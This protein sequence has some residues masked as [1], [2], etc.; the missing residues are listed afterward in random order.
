MPPTVLADVFIVP[1]K[2]IIVHTTPGRSVSFFG[3]HARVM[4]HRDMP[5]MLAR[6]DA[7]IVPTPFALSWADQWL[8]HTREIKAQVEWPEDWKVTH[9]SQDDFSIE[10]PE[11]PITVAPPVEETDPAPDDSFNG[12][13]SLID[14]L[15]AP[16][17]EPPKTKRKVARKRLEAA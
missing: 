15:M 3:G 6:E 17:A 2:S 8:A 16:D 7:R 12:A 11:Q 13:K 14:V 4:D 10:R 1:A 5:H 9:N